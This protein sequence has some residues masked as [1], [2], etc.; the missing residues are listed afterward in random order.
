MAKNNTYLND[1]LV[2]EGLVRLIVLG[3]LEQDA[4]HVGTGILVE[5]VARREDDQGDLAVAEHGQ[6]VGLLHHAELALVEGHLR[7]EGGRE[8]ETNTGNG[9]VS[10]S[11]KRWWQR[12]WKHCSITLPPVQ[13]FMRFENVIRGTLA[14]PN[15]N[16]G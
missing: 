7:G 13:I 6:L 14:G 12:K 16:P 4:I 1:V 8:N 10:G 5:L 2:G 15:P 11:G 3:V 9:S